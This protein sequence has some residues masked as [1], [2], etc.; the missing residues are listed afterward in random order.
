[1]E[2][3][4]WPDQLRHNNSNVGTQIC[5]RLV[6]GQTQVVHHE[7]SH[8]PIYLVADC[9]P[10]RLDPVYSAGIAAYS[11]AFVQY[12]HFF[13]LVL[14]Q[15]ISLSNDKMSEALPMADLLIVHIQGHKA[16]RAVDGTR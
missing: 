10:S 6:L 11:R 16:P 3:Y 12:L 1:M 9:M 14:D 5:Y 2:R 4:F 15:K 13:R 7:D 8:K